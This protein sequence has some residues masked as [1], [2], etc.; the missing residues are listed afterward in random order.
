MA[1][2]KDRCPT[3]IRSIYLSNACTSK[4]LVVLKSFAVGTR[5]CRTSGFYSTKVLEDQHEYCLP[6]TAYRPLILCYMCYIDTCAIC[7][8]DHTYLYYRAKIRQSLRFNETSNLMD[9][10]LTRNRSSALLLSYVRKCLFELC[11]NAILA[12]QYRLL[13]LNRH[14]IKIKL[15]LHLFDAVFTHHE[16][17]NRPSVQGRSL[18]LGKVNQ[19]DQLDLPSL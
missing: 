16:V 7:R 15:F 3:C 13:C 18:Y 2:G 4:H 12:E 17:A 1:V 14:S 19:R 10:T 5:P 8:R 9:V 6:L 11:K